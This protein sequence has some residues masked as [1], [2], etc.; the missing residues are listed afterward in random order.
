MLGDWGSNL[1]KLV[2]SWQEVVFYSAVL[3]AGGFALAKAL[4]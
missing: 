1:T 2:P 4:L 3:I